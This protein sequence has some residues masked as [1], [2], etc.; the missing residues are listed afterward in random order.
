MGHYPEKPKRVEDAL[1]HADH[2]ALSAMGRKG[3]ERAAFYRFLRE[4]A[5]NKKALED[6]LARAQ[7]ETLND[8]GDVLPPDQETIAA[9]EEAL[10]ALE[11][12]SSE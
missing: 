8:T 4:Q 9:I 12:D 5:R 1:R 6:A 11:R 7:V 10:A 3:A 2:D